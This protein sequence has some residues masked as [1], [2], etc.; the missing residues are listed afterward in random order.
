MAASEAAPFAKTGGLGDVAGSLFRHLSGAGL[1]VRLSMPLYRGLKNSYKLKPSGVEVV[2]PIG[3][4]RHVF[5]VFLYKDSVMFLECREFFERKELY[6]TPYGDYEDNALR[7]IAFSRAAL[8][9]CM[10]LGFIPDVVHC[11]DWQTA[12]M[13]YYVKTLYKRNFKKTATLLTIHNVGYQGLF[14]ASVMPQTGLDMK[15]FNPE[16][17]EYYGQVNFLKA[18]IVAAG[19][20]STVS[21]SYAREIT[22]AR[23]GHG[24]DGVLKKRSITGILNGI[25]YDQWNPGTDASLAVNY[26]SG[27]MAG[28]AKCKRLL[29]GE[30]SFKDE[31]APLLGMVGRLTYQKGIDLFLD[32]LDGIVGR[33]VNV[34]VLGRGE[35]VLQRGLSEASRR[36]PGEVSLTV[37]YDDAL[38]RRVFAAS[39]I[40]LMPSRYEPCGLAQMIAMRYGTIPV[41]RATGGLSD[42]ITDFDHLKSEGTGFL[43]SDYSPSALEECLK[44]ALCVYSDGDKWKSLMSNCMRADF[45]WE[46]SVK[47]YIG[48]YKTLIGRGGA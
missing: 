31:S 38:A 34:V 4:K 22:D 32:A 13:P 44:R 47:G 29:A 37:A 12:L 18:G 41:A 9:A 8:E 23:Y 40:F 28:K 45:S 35:A 17:L 26:D 7:F 27:D 3:K 10:S 5:R 15:L 25:D 30:L 43:F 19:A 33:G 1:E 21:P 24:L 20:V 16:G 48:L 14:P 2:I 39:D 42:T 36:F 6:G 46:K 11:N